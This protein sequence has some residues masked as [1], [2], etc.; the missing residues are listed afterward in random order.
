MIDRIKL[1]Q[2]IKPGVITFNLGYGHWGIGSSAVPIDGKI[3]KE[4]LCRGVGVHLNAAM[5][6][7]PYLKNTPLRIPSAEVQSLMIQRSG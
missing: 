4:D 2:T 6:I 7:D 3:I 5:W 1:T